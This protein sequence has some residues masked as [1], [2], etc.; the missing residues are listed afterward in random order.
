MEILEWGKRGGTFFEAGAADGMAGSNTLKLELKYGWTGLLVE[1]DPDNYGRLLRESSRN[2]L[3]VGACISRKTHPE[4]VLFDKAGLY[5]SIIVPGKPRSGD[6]IPSNQRKIIKESIAQ[7]RQTL[8][9]QCFPLYSMLKAAGMTKLDYISLDL[10]GIE[11][12]VLKSLPWEKVDINIISL[13]VTRGKLDE[14][15]DF[16]HVDQRDEIVNFLSQKEYE[17]IYE[18]PHTSELITYE[19]YFVHKSIPVPNKV[20]EKVHSYKSPFMFVGK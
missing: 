19:L 4:T 2:V 17:L 13:E 11:L 10:E 18:Q 12:E 6:N 1:A 20:K 14:S 16:E 5:G 15:L 8:R 7:I 9:M 3:S